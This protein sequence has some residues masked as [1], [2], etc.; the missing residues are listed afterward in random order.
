MAAGQHVRFIFLSFSEGRDGLGQHGVF[1]LWMKMEI[2]TSCPER[3]QFST[4]DGNF[5]VL[6]LIC[7]ANP[8]VKNVQIYV[9]LANFISQ[10]STTH[11]S[12]A[13]MLVVY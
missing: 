5:K 1:H 11:T 3:S 6:V 12:T 7:N 4:K 10:L 2:G 13:T 9:P 8:E